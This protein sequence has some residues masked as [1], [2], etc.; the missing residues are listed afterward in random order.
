MRVDL[1]RTYISTSAIQAL[2]Q[3]NRSSL[4][5]LR[6]EF[7][8]AEDPALRVIAQAENLEY[9]SLL[10]CLSFSK[11]GLR[12]FLSKRLP[13][14]LKTLNIRL[15]S[16]V[17]IGWLYKL[18]LKPNNIIETID[19]S[20]CERLTLGDLRSLQK[21]KPSLKILHTARLEEENIWGYRKYIEYLSSLPPVLSQAPKQHLH[22]SGKASETCGGPPDMFKP[23][24]P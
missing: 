20:G 2:I 23:E 4:R 17:R 13:T 10:G 8:N 12:L 14:M 7:S 6:L 21:L 11:C 3:T 24:C 5:S 9:L 1:S 16:D 15:L 18:L 19:V 22:C